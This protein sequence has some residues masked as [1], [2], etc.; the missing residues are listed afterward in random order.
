MSTKRSSLWRALEKP[1]PIWLGGSILGLLACLYFAFGKTVGV[2]T[3]LLYWGAWV[4]EY[5][6][7]EPA[8]WSFFRGSQAKALAG[9]FW[10]DA[11]SLLT[12]GVVAGSLLAALSAS[13]FRLR[14][15]A[16]RK[17]LLAAI[18][19]GFLM[20]YGGRIAGT[21]NLGAY[22]GL[23]PSQS[24]SGWVFLAFVGLGAGLGSWLLWKYFS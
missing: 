6:G 10:R 2:Q 3:S 17:Q 21:C 23:L 11:G 13:E 19:G 24:L 18:L 20:G 1:W 8:S 4:G 12:L 7:L 16:S 14:K 15:I 9:G 22:F 5:L